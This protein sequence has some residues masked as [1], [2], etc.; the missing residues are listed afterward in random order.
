M[1][2]GA[3]VALA[4]VLVLALAVGGAALYL[5][6][7]TS[8]KEYHASVSQDQAARNSVVLTALAH[9][10]IHEAVASVTSD[11]VYVAY[12]A[13]SANGDAAKM[14]EM[15]EQALAAAA[16]GANGAPKAIIVQYVAEKPV[17]Q[18]EASLARVADLK[19]GTLSWDD[20]VASATKTT[21]S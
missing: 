3:K 20:F 11:L 4:I 12:A 19:A 2:T 17:L 1:K 9:A 10:G 13:D 16:G 14:E 15:Q 8:A 21:K 18:W 7:P 6:R 5:L